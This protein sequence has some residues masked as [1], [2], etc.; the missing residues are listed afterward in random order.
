MPWFAI[1]PKRTQPFRNRTVGQLATERLNA[2]APNWLD[3]SHKVTC[4]D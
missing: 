1:T 2:S 4:E 3:I